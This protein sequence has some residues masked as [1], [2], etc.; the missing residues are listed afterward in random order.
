M[1]KNTSLN[2]LQYIQANGHYSTG[3]QVVMMCHKTLQCA[4]QR[5][6]KRASKH[7]CK[8]C[9]FKNIYIYVKKKSTLKMF[10]KKENTFNM[11]VRLFWC[12][13]L[14]V[15]SVAFGHS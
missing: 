1:Y 8:Q 5:Q 2:N 4:I 12:V 13:T 14:N 15:L 10:H 9:T 7:G 11:F 3:L 6:R